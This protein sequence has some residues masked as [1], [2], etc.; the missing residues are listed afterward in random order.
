DDTCLFLGDVANPLTFSNITVENFR[1]RPM[2]PGGTRPMVEDNSGN[3]RILNTTARLPLAG[4][5]FGYLIQVDNDQNAILD[6]VDPSMANP[7]RCDASFCG[8]AIFAPGPFSSNAALGYVK[9]ANLTMNC[10]GNGIDWQS[11]NT[12]RISDSVI[13]GY[14]QFAVRA[15][16]KR[17]GYGSYEFDNVYRERGNCINPPGSSADR[18]GAA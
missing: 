15:G 9:N 5:S 2:V 13:Q 11:G 18:L 1:G 16:T 3:A 6:G 7:I 17:G 10:S 4:N 8:A 12:L 14:V